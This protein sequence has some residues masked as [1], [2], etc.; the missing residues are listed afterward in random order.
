M[1]KIIIIGSMFTVIVYFMASTFGYLTWVGNEQALNDLKE[2]NILQ[3]D[4]KGNIAFSI[5]TF[6]LLIAVFAAGPL[7]ILPSKDAYEELVYGEQG[8]NK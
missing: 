8:M 3:M 5:S 1:D 6:G 2:T 7:L 4:Y